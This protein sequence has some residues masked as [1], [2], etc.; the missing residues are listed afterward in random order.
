[1]IDLAQLAGVCDLHEAH[2][3]PHVE[4]IGAAGLRAFLLRQPDFLFRDGG[5]LVERCELAAAG[6]HARP[7]GGFVRRRLRGA[8]CSPE[9]QSRLS[10]IAS[11]VRRSASDNDQIA[12]KTFSLTRILLDMQPR[13]WGGNRS[14]CLPHPE[15]VINRIITCYSGHFRGPIR[16]GLL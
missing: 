7:F 16:A 2:E 5:E 10:R 3:V 11:S 8:A 12:A 13:G 15:H 6:R 9:P 14:T 4:L 1:M